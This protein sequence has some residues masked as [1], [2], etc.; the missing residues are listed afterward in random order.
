MGGDPVECLACRGAGFIRVVQ[1]VEPVATAC[2]I[3]AVPRTRLC[4]STA[5]A[6]DRSAAAAA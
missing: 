1:E 2:S 6:T 4:S 5:P 3:S